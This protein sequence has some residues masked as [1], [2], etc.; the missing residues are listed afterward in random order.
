MLD[1]ER[2]TTNDWGPGAADCD[3][4]TD[5]GVSP[6]NC[7]V[8]TQEIRTDWQGFVRN[9]NGEIIGLFP[10]GV[11]LGELERTGTITPNADGGATIDEEARSGQS[12]TSPNPDSFDL[13]GIKIGRASCRER[14]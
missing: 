12:T 7:F 14:V 6:A 9:E 13:T 2:T 3:G 11:T 4:A 10:F 1:Y 8:A 5:A